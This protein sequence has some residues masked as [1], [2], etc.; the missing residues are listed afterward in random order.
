MGEN[1]YGIEVGLS[2]WREIEAEREREERVP[3]STWK[4][5]FSL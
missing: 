4:T 2:L 5:D 3:R 1:N